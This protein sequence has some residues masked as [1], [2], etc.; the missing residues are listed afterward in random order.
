MK[1]RTIRLIAC[2]LLVSATFTTF[3]QNAKKL[4]KSGSQ[5]SKIGS[6]EKAIELYSEAISLNPKFSKAIEAR[7]NAYEE[8][9]KYEMA[10]EDYE[11]LTELEPKDSKLYFKAGSL[12]CKVEKYEKAIPLLKTVSELAPE[13]ADCYYLKSQSY[14]AL[15]NYQE[16]LNEISS[17]IKLISSAENFYQRGVIYS[18][19]GNY[20][21]AK[22]DLQM[23]ISLKD[24][25]LIQNLILI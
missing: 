15:K 12:Y 7:A 21:S 9:S 23:S 14:H 18:D 16:A 3:S 19:T 17:A 10:A 4:F 24:W 22:G 25:I 2:I 11:T 5:Y 6:F 20:K 1:I 13:N 8:I